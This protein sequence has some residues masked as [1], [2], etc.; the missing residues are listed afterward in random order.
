MAIV[1]ADDILTMWF[2]ERVQPLWFNATPA[3]D[4]ELREHYTDT[5]RAALVGELSAW[6]MTPQGVLALVICLDQLPLN[7]YRGRPESF[8]GVVSARQVAD[9]AIERG[10]DRRLDDSGKVFLFMPFMH[11]ESLADQDY[12]VAL[13]AAAGLA[14]NLRWTEH[15]RDIVRRFGRFPHRNAIL[16][17]ESTPAE[18]V[19]LQS[20]EGFQG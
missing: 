9:T 15:H 18:R 17:R 11:S 7:M 19:Y 2:S 20:G 1:M 4:A 13:F 8:A 10:F 3:F 14:D 6:E 12:S 16:G 5:C